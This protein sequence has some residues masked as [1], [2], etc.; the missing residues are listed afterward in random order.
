MHNAAHHGHH[1]QRVPRYRFGPLERRGLVGNLRPGQI[2]VL[3]GAVFATVLTVQ[4][5]ESGVGLALG[6]MIL[7]LGAVAA[8]IPF[9]GRVL[10][11]WVPVVWVFALRRLFGKHRWKS[12]AAQAGTRFYAGDVPVSLPKSVGKV[13]LLTFPFRGVELGVLA[14]RAA[15]TYTAVIQARARSFALLDYEDKAQRLAAWAG[16]ISGLAREGSPITRVQWVERT[17]PD[18][19]NGLNRYLREALDPSIPIDSPQLQSY[20][21]LTRAAGPATE[22][23]ELFI[24]LQLSAMRASR[25]IRQAGGK[26]TGACTVL[27]RELETFARR[28]DAAEVEVLHALGPRRL[29]A[30]IRLGYDPNARSMINRLGSADPSRDDGVSAR[31][32]WPQ[33][34]ETQWSWYQTNDVYHCTYWVAE[35]PR[36]EVGPEFLAPLLV[37]TRVMRTVSVTMEPVPTI[38][39]MRSVNFAKTADIAD[40]AM[41]E[42]MGFI[43]TARRRQQADAVGRREQ[44]LTD[45]HAD[46][47]FSGYVTVTAGSIDELREACGEV[48]HAAS[49]ARLELQRCD[50][51]QEQAFTWTLPLARG[52]S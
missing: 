50:G 33:R 39:A 51:E 48:E 9:G 34:T 26:D 10:H 44:E 6:V 27:A 47:R 28:L 49:L 17:V 41:R 13:E 16:V 20:L 22:Q 3:G 21:A 11:E 32:A 7:S 18:D 19:G 25:L 24:V 2:A 36:V 15:G 40:E 8:F 1:V 4:T 5:F 35:W 38:K 31:N 29:A 42:R 30:S 45:G 46:V 14:D 52:L 12:T 43:N 23:H 37:Q